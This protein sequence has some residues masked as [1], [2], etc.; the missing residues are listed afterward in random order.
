MAKSKLPAGITARGEHFR[1]SV[2]VAGVRRTAT[3]ETLAE[4]VRVAAEFRSGAVVDQKAPAWTLRE[5]GEAFYTDHVCVNAMPGA[6]SF[7]LSFR[8]LHRVSVVARERAA[9]DPPPLPRRW[10][11]NGW[12]RREVP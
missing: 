11:P 12:L 4:A 7:T 3:L 9:F 5:A 10:A 8:C 1:V 2:M 6:R